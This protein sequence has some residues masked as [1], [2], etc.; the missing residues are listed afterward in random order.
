MARARSTTESWSSRDGDGRVRKVAL[1]LL[2]TLAVV[3]AMMAAF[4]EDAA[5]VAISIERNRSGLE[6]QSVVVDGETWHY[7]EG[8]APEAPVLL[9]LHGF[10]GDKDNW[11]RFSRTLVRDYRVIAPDLPGF[12]DSARH[13]DWDYS[14]PAQRDRLDRFIDTLKLAPLHIGGNSMGGHLAVLYTHAHPENIRSLILL[15]N[16]GIDAPRESEM[17][18]AVSRG[19]NPL[20][21]SSAED[22]DRLISFV[23]YKPPFL[24]W[25]VKDVLAEKTFKNAAFNRYIFKAR[26]GERY[27]PLEPLLGDLR[28]PVLIIWGEHDRVLDVSS[29][30]VMRPLLPQAEIIVMPETGH[31]PMLERPTETA[32]HYLAFLA[33]L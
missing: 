11:T 6:L 4:P 16:S 23:S 20:V 10:G 32:A 3:V 33:G 5:R 22:F 27:V 14:L 9:L 29:I 7:L 17:A 19:E 24:P 2:A 28:Q 8:G 18:Q 12:G 21:V 1:W 26:R 13:A 25:P 31:I 30:D 15:D